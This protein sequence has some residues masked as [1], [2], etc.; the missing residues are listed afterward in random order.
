MSDKFEIFSPQHSTN[1][2]T[3]IGF[4]STHYALGELID[5]SIQSAIEDKK[6]K[7]CDV[8]LIGIDKNGKLSNLIVID[9]A[10]GMSPEILRLSLGVGRVS[11]EPRTKLDLSSSRMISIQSS[12]HSLQTNTFGPAISLRTSC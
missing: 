9:D 12:T 10:G 2:L 7:S 5:N 4:K 6:N 1:S 8:Q 11:S 3:Q